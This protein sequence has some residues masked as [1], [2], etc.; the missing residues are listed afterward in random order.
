MVSHMKANIYN[1]GLQRRA[2]QDLP[3]SPLPLTSHPTTLPLPCPLPPPSHP[4]NFIPATL[5]SISS[6]NIHPLL[7]E[8]T[9]IDPSVWNTPPP[10]IFVANSSI[11][12]KFLL[13][14]N[15]GHLVNKAT[16]TTA[17]P[18][19]YPALFFSFFHS[20]YHLTICIIC[21]CLLFNIYFSHTRAGL[22]II[23]VAH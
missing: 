15:F 20:T 18:S 14:K 17:Y 10:D 1:L 21:L 23:C 2:Q 19:F 16:L 11:S 4:Y 7:K 13:K 9:K 8:F 22:Y 5:A 12:I 6:P 3:P